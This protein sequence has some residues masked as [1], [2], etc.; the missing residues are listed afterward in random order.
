MAG[1]AGECVSASHS[2]R[3]AGESV[4]RLLVLCGGLPAGQPEDQ[5]AAESI[6]QSAIDSKLSIVQ[7]SSDCLTI[8]ETGDEHR[9][10]KAGC[11]CF[12]R[13]CV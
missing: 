2:L 13:S 4:H 7:L 6:C 5:S 10:R 11:E 1:P 8:L 3:N 9:F 12:K